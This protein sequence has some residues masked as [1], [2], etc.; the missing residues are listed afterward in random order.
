MSY[1]YFLL[2]VIAFESP[3]LTLYYIDI[4]YKIIFNIRGVIKRRILDNRLETS[5][6]KPFFQISSR[7][8]NSFLLFLARLKALSELYNLYIHYKKLYS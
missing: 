8:L 7:N 3:Y 6:K 4:F 2:I 1:L 5:S